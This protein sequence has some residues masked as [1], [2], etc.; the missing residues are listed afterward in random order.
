MARKYD[1]IS[2]LYRRTAHAVVSDVENWQAFLR[3]ACRNYRL[4]FDEQLLI[5][6]QRPDATA[7]LEIERWNDKF[8]RWVNRGAKGIAVFE[9]ADRS[10]QR[11]THYFDISDTHASRYSRPVPIWEMKPEYTDDVIESLENTFGELENRESLADA[12]LSAA[13]N[14]VEDNIPDY[15]GDLMYA[16]DDSFLYGLSEDMITAMYKKAVTNSVAYM[17]MARLGIDTEPF[18]EAEDFSV[19]TNFNTP[20]T[21]NALGIASSDI[22]EM[23]LGEISRTV[24]ALERQNRIIADREKSEYNKAENKIERSFDDERADIHNAGRL[25]SAGFDNAAAAGGNFGQ[26][27]SDE[28]EISQRTSQNPLLQSSDELHSD[29][30]FSRNRA[31]SDE[32]GRNPDE[33][34]G[35]AGGLDR[36]PESGGYDE[37]GAGNEQSEEQS[38]GNRES[39]GHLRLDYYDRSNEDKSLL[40][41]SGDD[42]I[43]EILGTTPHLK[44]SK[45]EIRAFYEHNPDNAARTEYIKGIFN[46]DHTELI[47]SDG[48]RVGYKTWQNVLQLWEGNY[49]DR[50]A[51][52]FYDWSVIAQHFEAMRLLGELQ[53]TMKPLPSMDG[54]L[55]FLDMQAE[56]K[57]SAFSFSQEIIDTILTR[58]SGI[59]E[60]KFRIYEQFE[61]SLSAKENTDFLKNEY[62]WGSAYPVIVGTGI[63]EQHDGK[64]ILISKGIG[65]DKPHIRLTWTQVEKRIAELIRLDR[66]LNPK[67]KEIYPQWLEKQEERRAELAEKQRNREILSS[68]PPEQETVQAAKSEPQQEAQYAYHLGDTVYMGADEYEILAF[69][70]KR[71]VLHDM[72]YPLFQ[73][74]L[75]RDEFDSKVRENPMNDHLKETNQ[76]AVTEQPRFNSFEFEKLIPHNMRFKETALV[77]GNEMYWVTQEIFTAGDLRKFQQAVQSYN[78]DI[79][80]FYV[81]PR[82]LS[83]SYSFEEDMENKVLAVITPDTILQDDYIQAVRNEG[84]GDY[85]QPE[86][87]ADSAEAP[88]FDIGMGYLGNGLTVWNRAVEENGDYQTIA[89]IS[90]EG[91]IHYYVDGLPED[92]VARIEQAAAQEQQK[93]LFSATYKIGDKVY[94]DG[95]P[96]E[97]TRVDDWNVTLMDRSV[98]NPQP[99]LERKDSFMRLV[100]QNE[101]NSRFAA[102][103]NEYSEI[104]SDNPD[105]LVLYQM[106]DFFEAYGEDAQTVS[107]ALELNLTSRSIGNNQRTGMCGFPANRLETYVNML[108]DRGFDV[109]VSS[110]ENGERNTRNIVSSNKEDPV[111]SQPI[112]RIDYLHTDGTVRESVE[113]TSLYQ[114]EKDIKEETFYGVPFTVVFY[115]DKD[116]NTVP[117][118]FIGSLDPQPKGVEIIDSPYLANDRAAENMLPP[119]ERFFVIETDDG[120]AIWDDLT[121][122]IYIDNEG[123][124]EEFKS[125]WQANDYLEQVKKSVSELDTAKALIDEYCRDEFEREEGADYTDLS[126][127]ELAYT[128][129]ED[130]KHEIQARVNL[131]DY[132]LETLADGN[133]IRSEQ[134]SSLEDM[135][136]RSLQSLS[137]NDLV[138]LSDEELE[139]AEQNSAKQPT[140]EK[141]EPLTPAFSQ[142][143]R[144]R[145][146]TFDLHPDIPMSERHTFDLAFHEVPEAGKKERFR[147]NMEAIR[148][149]KECEFDN[150]FATPEEQEIL[151]QYV[152]W[153]GIPEA[154][155]ENNSSWADEFIE[156]Y[157]ALSPDEYESA[158]AST[159][160]AFYTPP[161]VI[162]SIYKAMEQMGFKEGNILEPSC[163]IGN[164]IG[165]LPSSMQDSKIYGV[166]IDKISA[167]IAQQ[168]Y[169]KT[170]IAAQP[171]EEANIP[172]SFFDAVIGN[173]PFGDIRVN[174]RRY[175]KHNFLI[176]DYFFAKSLD[177]LRPGGVMA[178]ITSK[179]TMDKEN[180]AVRRYI[181]Q[182]ADLLGAIRLPNNTFKGN[183][184]TEVVSD[185][186]ILQK[187]DRLIDLE[188]EWVHL[189]TD[190][191]GV[192]MNAYFVDHP[193]M[194]LGEWK[195]V[196]GRFGEEDTVVPYENADLAELLNEAISN[197]HAEITDYEVDEEL[198]EEDHS[199]PAD[200]EVRNFSYT[201]VDD[202]IYYRENSRMTPVECSATAENRIKGMIAIRNSVRSLIEMQTADYPDYEVEKEQQKLNALYDTF[203]KKYGLINSRANVSAFSQ[204]S[205]FALLSALEV[206]DENGELERK[207][208]MFTKRTIKPHTPVTSVDTASEALAV[209]MG[210]KAY[211]DM[212]Y[213]CS[214]T[215][216]TEEE[217][218]QELKGVIFLNPMYGY[219]GSTEQKYLMADEYLSG[220]VREKL[221]WAK[222]SAEVYPEDY[223]INV[224]ALEK[225][226]PKDLTAS[227]I[228]VQLGTTWLPEEIAQQFMYE[229]LDTPRYAQWNIKVHYSKLTGEWNVEG[230]SYDR[231]N[232]KAYNTYGTKRVNAYKIIEDTLNMKDVRVFDYMED[233]EGKK[234]AVLNKKETA[235]AQSKQEL[236]KQGFQDWV[237]RDPARREK[238][239]RLYNDKFNSIRPREYDGSHIIFSGMNPEIELREHQKNAVAHIL[240]GGNTL[241]AHAV[242]AGK[243]FEMT[244]A[245]MESKRLGLCNKSLFVVPNHLTEQWAAEFLQLYPAANILVATKKDFEMKNRK[246]FCGRIATG[247]YD[248]VIIGHSQFEKIPISIERQ[249][250]VLEQQLSDIIEGIADIK[251]NRGD[252]FSVKQ[253]EKTKR[254]LQTKLEKLN[255]QSR[256]DDVVTFEELGID[257][258]FI[259]E[260][261]YYKNLYLYTKMRNVGGIAQTEAQKSSDLFMKCRYLDE[262]TGGRGVVFA[263]GT[264]ISNSMVELYTIQ[265]YLQ[266]RTLQEHDLQHFDAWA[267]M[268]GETVTA[269]ELTPEGTGYRAKT[270][271]AKF[272]NLPELMAMFK[273]VADIKTADMLD[274]P[275]PEVEYHNIAV[276]PSQVQKEMVAS[277][278]ERAEKIRG[279]NV[280]SSVDNML[281]VTNDGRKLALDQRMMNPMLPDEEGSKVNACVNEVF[282]IWEENSDKKLTQL[283]FCD[284]STPKGAGEFSVYTDIRQKLIERG[285]PESEIKFIHE[286]DTEAKK[287]ELFK[288]VRRGEVRILMGSTQ[289]MGAG[290]NVQNKIIASHD[291]DCPW[292]PADLEQRAGRTVRQGNE[293]PKV[294]LYRYVT[295]GTFDAY[296]WQLVEG[297]QKFSSQIMT[298]KSPVR[299]CEDVDATA[300]SYAEIKMLAADNPHIKEKMDLDIQVQ[301]LRLLKS[302]YL[303]EK[304]ELED[305]IIKYYPTTIA[306][307]KE[308]IAG[309]EKDILLAKEHPKPLDDTFVGI[310]V[311]GVSYSEKAEGGQKI[312]DACKEMT[313]PDP[314]P[315]GKYRGFDLELSFDTFEKA[316]QVKIKGSLSR[317][318]SL[319][320]DA[321]GNITRIDNA[322]EKI[323][324]RLEAKSRELSTLEQ[325]FATAKAEVEKP[326]DKEEELTE[327]TNRLNVLNG[328]LNVDKREN[329]LV[330]GAPDEGDS[331]P[332]PKERAYER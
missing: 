323:S 125:E 261:H 291:L 119:D 87:K 24:L 180:P 26:V 308:T 33:A 116:G 298:S 216:K 296:C 85:L 19:I 88:A 35:G 190:E 288:K 30:A 122:A 15:L 71:V 182:R 324:E 285:I 72:Q 140:P 287:Q 7:V 213:M 77:N 229:F 46:N 286:A 143:K 282:R 2:E 29:G 256:K 17:M 295:E 76:V 161:V 327:K 121:E 332:T 101:N 260:S 9:D 127:V 250:A 230:K 84:L 40:F 246:R 292:R 37:V 170:S 68:A 32:A 22:A 148:V 63:D 113:Y 102:F 219:G 171:F 237:W 211:V 235:I 276:K 156:L 93:A 42:T 193:E 174:D 322:I 151:S 145:I 183:A 206:L 95:K 212:E 315:L 231:S 104:K 268:F 67:E 259:D 39:G 191:N 243:T 227:E 75:E 94:L 266:Y 173:V 320:T 187:R 109:A 70:D 222:K 217:I 58:G 225:V 241:L 132:R 164:F 128:T 325:Q 53:D 142:Q 57:P 50:I 208:D 331:V 247:D 220:N 14:A 299:S 186:L 255:D 97:I 280:D 167:G 141:N 56:E 108:L 92:V 120:Y 96:F 152:G 124:R 239:V 162:S 137:F 307:T 314:V 221:A 300:L 215:G 126:N 4:R 233:D 179:G 267:S 147:R 232:L 118:D 172:D 59:S 114:F 160:T 305:K 165:M 210:E 13:K 49:A 234:K 242:G 309:L 43:R 252:R 1:L 66:Y 279:G 265:R 115:K 228:F 200:P 192:K 157:T 319:G 153:G 99:R 3:C 310:E 158:R 73:K 47:L 83:P 41:F 277:L 188:P 204:D 189:N 117:Q 278:G 27:R 131:V 55:N 297:K 23:G 244:A 198:T 149:L 159:L 248:A 146:Q 135:I 238:L 100:Q 6:A 106:D 107:E 166:E 330:D 36:E 18:F 253:L 69:D 283:L 61:K 199:I 214:L 54:Q 86:E 12:V 11:L 178:L 155:D 236:I 181:A 201:V 313:S 318:V 293:N 275:V 31:D 51:Q 224:E 21:L 81:T 25:Q 205:S 20:E 28:A 105:S 289:K 218:Y 269:V 134:F 52:G 110:L 302:N 263:T 64:G 168:L 65:D 257:R 62:G 176:H 38:A 316:Y 197:I 245:A 185:I 195:T 138:Y 271:F 144:S 78:G 223:K 80:K 8:G 240:Y 89:H 150:R 226:Q 184:G 44:A 175:N 133:V 45:E 5:Y 311:K 111:Q 90:N 264:P 98:Q 16:A 294:G 329:E 82:D 306:R 163:G 79:K 272:N 60:G 249:R 129:T 281:K 262:I 317:S 321:T 301:T 207:A 303:S 274:L 203:S 177:K 304:Y 209:S 258:L 123:V 10:R 290:T 169:Q 328:L 136:E 74:E 284:L 194:V 103:Y 154:F 273:Q 196:S 48:R 326:F 254:S 312:I 91:E 139:M 130:D 251:R 202:K 34:D 270:R 112:G